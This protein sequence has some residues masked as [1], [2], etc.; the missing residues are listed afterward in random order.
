MPISCLLFWAVTVPKLE[1]AI[2]VD[3]LCFAGQAVDYRTV[4][5]NTKLLL[6]PIAAQKV[7]AT[8]FVVGASF[9]RYS[10][11]E[12]RRLY[13]LWTSAG[14]EL[15]NHTW[16]HANLDSTK[17]DDYT[18]EIRRTSAQMQDVLGRRP[19][20]FRAPYLNNGKE[21]AVKEGLQLFLKEQ[22]LQE[23]PVT[24]DTDDWKIA[25]AYDKAFAAGDKAL[26]DKIAAAYVP[27][28]EARTAFFEQQAKAF[29]GRPIRQ[30]LL[31]HA[32]RINARQMPELLAMFRK[33]GYRF[34]SLATALQDPAYK[35]ADDYLGSWGLSWIYR[36][37][38]GKGQEIV[39][40]PKLPDWVEKPG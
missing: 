6:K 40:G 30:I 1:V 36:W 20:Y 39:E 31:S 15:G 5:E 13:A 7:P 34:V 16:T 14:C 24:I 23:A 18:E 2:T 32:N 35:T 17:L 21:K 11:D 29:F 9:A 19:R 12:T 33:R 22:K 3:D 8:G 4:E 27:Y 26:M 38:L 37:Q 28:M 10:R 25:E